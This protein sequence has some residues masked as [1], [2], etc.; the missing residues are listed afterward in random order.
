MAGGFAHAFRLIICPSTTKT[1]SCAVTLDVSP[2]SASYFRFKTAIQ[3]AMLLTHARIH[4]KKPTMD[5]Q[6]PP[7]F[8]LD[9]FADPRSV[10]DVVKGE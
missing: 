2:T 6:E 4:D 10:R 1:H 9:V 7:E 5:Q 3:T 8:I